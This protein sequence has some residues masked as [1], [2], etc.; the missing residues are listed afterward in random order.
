MRIH[1]LKTPSFG[2]L[3]NRPFLG[4]DGS[5]DS[6]KCLPTTFKAWL[7]HHLPCASSRASSAGD[8]DFIFWAWPHAR[9]PTK[10]PWRRMGQSKQR[11]VGGKQNA[12]REARIKMCSFRTFYPIQPPYHYVKLDGSYFSMPGYCVKRKG[13]VLNLLAI[14]HFVSVSSCAKAS[15]SQSFMRLFH[16]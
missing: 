16:A 14:D 6:L 4:P 11:Q 5:I 15:R 7:P 12:H 9:I 13:Y 10:M 3:F 8:Y 2:S 1:F